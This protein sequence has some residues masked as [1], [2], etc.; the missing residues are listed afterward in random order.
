[1]PAQLHN[2]EALD[3]SEWGKRPDTE[4][5]AS[6][7]VHKSVI[8]YWRGQF[9]I[10]SYLQFRRNQRKTYLEHG[11]HW[12]GTCQRYLPVDCF[13]G[14][15]HHPGGLRARCKE[16]RRLYRKE[17]GDQMRARNREHY[18]KNRA[19]YAAR[20]KKSREKNKEK[21]SKRGRARHGALKA[22]F[23]GLAG[24][25]CQRCGYDEFT[26]GMDFH[27]V[28][29]QTKQVRPSST[30]NSGDFDATFLELDK[31]A[32]L[33]RNCH[34]AFHGNDWEAQFVKRDGMGWTIAM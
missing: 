19:D 32:L 8:A 24:G 9:G 22:R 21:I 29:G 31:C 33:C 27:H 26:S 12:C 20:S 16:C 1:M 10:P 11:L 15:R 23:V 14:S 28:D 3:K 2:W 7:G 6:L 4:I 13:G 25:C 34:Q 30:I 17:H 5:G 18:A